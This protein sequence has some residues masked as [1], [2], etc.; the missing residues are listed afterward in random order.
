MDLLTKLLTGNLG[1]GVVIIIVGLFIFV[2][3]MFI[4]PKLKDYDT[5][6]NRLRSVEDEYKAKIDEKDKMIEDG[7][8]TIASQQTSIEEQIALSVKL[9]DTVQ[10]IS[11]IDTL[12]QTNLSLERAIEVLSG[13]IKVLVS[14][15]DDSSKVLN[16]ELDRLVST[17]RDTTESL[18]T[19]KFTDAETA[20]KQI[21]ARLGS[22]EQLCRD[23]VNSSSSTSTQLSTSLSSI[24]SGISDLRG[25]YAFQ[26]SRAGGEEMGLYDVK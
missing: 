12:Q 9:Q 2:Y 11:S 3:Q 17:L 13:E 14:K 23:I 7:L 24:E 10:K 22:V 25:M 20:Q 16:A 19:S 15:Q 21:D 1:Y 4:Q 8:E 26:R 6:E 18:L 5:L